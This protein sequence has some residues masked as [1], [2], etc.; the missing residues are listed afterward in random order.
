MIARKEID[1]RRTY[2]LLP[3]GRVASTLR[4]RPLLAELRRLG[5]PGVRPTATHPELLDLYERHVRSTAELMR[6]HKPFPRGKD[7]A[8]GVELSDWVA[9]QAAALIE[10]QARG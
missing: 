6:A 8:P 4:L 3:D 1:A 2:L 10:Q 9:K 7:T 5:I